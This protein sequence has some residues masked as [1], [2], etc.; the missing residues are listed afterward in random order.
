MLTLSPADLDLLKEKGISEEELDR[1]IQCFKRGFP[2]LRLA[3]SARVGSGILPL[4]SFSRHNAILRWQRFLEEEGDRDGV[5]KFT[6][7][8]GAASRMFKTVHAFVNGES[9]ALGLYPEIAE[10]VSNIHRLPFYE[11]LDATCRKLYSKN[12]DQLLAEGRIRDTFKALIGPEGLN[13]GN[14]PKGLLLFHTYPFGNRTPLEEQ[15]VEAARYV[16]VNGRAKIHFTVSAEHLPLF[17]DTIS[18]VVGPLQDTSGI[19]FDISTSVQKPSTDT[20]AVNLDGTPHYEDGRIMFRPGGHGS[21]IANLNDIDKGVVFIKNIDNV[22]PESIAEETYSYKRA[23]GGILLQMRDAIHGYITRLEE[24]HNDPVLQKEVIEYLRDVLFI[25]DPRFETLQGEEL[26]SF[27][28]EKLNRPIRVCGMVKNEGE[29]GGGPFLAYSADGSVAPQILEMSQIDP[30]NRTYSRMVHMA[31]HFNPVDLVCYIKDYKG[32][33]FDLRKYVDD[34]TGFISEK[35]IKGVPVLAMEHPGLWNGAMSDWNTVF[36][37]VP[38]S[39]FNPVKTVNDLLRP[40]HC[41][42]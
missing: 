2:Y 24:S 17:Q 18:R 11:E 29:P 14:L 40:T 31:T 6:P 23:L 13:Y 3:D 12:V 20:V 27:L 32:R 9:D 35:S 26:T 16:A 33:K 19:I 15:L 1:Q 39:T 41:M 37:E 42:H 5:I 4:S 21:L 10:L 28:L 22:V 30:S 8:S 38:V 25:S 34:N 36:V 7:A